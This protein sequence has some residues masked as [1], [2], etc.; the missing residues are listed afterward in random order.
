MKIK[1]IGHA[2]KM[3]IGFPVGAPR[4]AQNF[5][6]FVLNEAR[7]I[8]DEQG[9]ALLATDPDGRAFKKVEEKKKPASKTKKKEDGDE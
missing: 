7:E 9:K 1:Y 2:P 3:T 8:S 4:H 6:D 5:V